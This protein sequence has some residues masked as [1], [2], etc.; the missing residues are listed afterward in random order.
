MR[1]VEFANGMVAK[2]RI[3]TVD[4]ERRRVVYSALNEAFVH[5]SSSMQIVPDGDSRCRFIWTTDIL[6]ERAR[7]KIAPLVD[8]GCEALKKS[9]EA[10]K[11]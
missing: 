8:A 5:H 9:L 2:E 7:D 6:P 3:V 1:T 4:D 11:A 10:G